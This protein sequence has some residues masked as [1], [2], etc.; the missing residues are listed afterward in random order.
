MCPYLQREMKILCQV[1]LPE[2]FC[3]TKIQTDI[4]YEVNPKGCTNAIKYFFSIL[5]RTHEA[6]TNHEIWI[7]EMIKYP[8]NF[9]S[10]W[11]MQNWW[12]YL[13]QKILLHTKDKDFSRIY[14]SHSHQFY[15]EIT[16]CIH[17]SRAMTTLNWWRKKPKHCV[18][19]LPLDCKVPR[20]NP[21]SAS[22]ERRSGLSALISLYLTTH[23]RPNGL[24]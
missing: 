13:S 7:F 22:C 10:A 1:G 12:F 8:C 17:F 24:D 2:Y 4:V 18:A 9:D 21:A 6:N 20:L 23:N 5:I 3:I 19:E 15:P 11:C 16:A 14:I